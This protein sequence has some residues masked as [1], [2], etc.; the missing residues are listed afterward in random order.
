MA[1]EPVVS[2]VK[3]TAAPLAGLDNSLHDAVVYVHMNSKY[4]HL[5]AN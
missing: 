2:L 3:V 4:E 1:M 5:V